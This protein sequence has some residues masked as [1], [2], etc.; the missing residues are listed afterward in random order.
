MTF[1][2]KFICYFSVS[3]DYVKTD[4]PHHEAFEDE[5]TVMPE[6]ESANLEEAE[7]EGHSVELG[8]DQPSELYDNSVSIR[9]LKKILY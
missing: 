1:S 7:I 6:N 5:R 9:I 8:Y 3:E 2:Y 4:E